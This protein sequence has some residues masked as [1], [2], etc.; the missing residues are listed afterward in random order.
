MCNCEPETLLSLL[1]DG[2]HWIFE[3]MLMIIFDGIV[4]PIVWFLIHKHFHPKGH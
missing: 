1:S 3:I 2:N 4:G